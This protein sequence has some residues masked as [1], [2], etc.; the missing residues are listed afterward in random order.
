MSKIQG[1][2]LITNHNVQ[3]EILYYLVNFVLIFFSV[4]F[5]MYDLYP[6]GTVQ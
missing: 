3:C 5:K 4:K 6:L 1:R 2:V